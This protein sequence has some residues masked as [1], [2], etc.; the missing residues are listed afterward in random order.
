MILEKT[1]FDGNQLMEQSRDIRGEVM[2]LEKLKN[3][4]DKIT[5][6]INNVKT[7]KEEKAF[8]VSRIRELEGLLDEK[9]QEL[10]QLKSEKNMVKNQ[11][12]GLLKELETLESE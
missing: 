8:M 7:L 12:E 4:E 1:P 9:N 3:L 6:V 10:E 11:I 5:T 2:F